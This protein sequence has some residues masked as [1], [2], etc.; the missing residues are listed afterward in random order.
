[1]EWKTLIC[2]TFILL[3]QSVAV[4]TPLIVI[5]AFTSMKRAERGDVKEASLGKT[6]TAACEVT[7]YSL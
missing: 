1:M 2:Y 5:V 4:F 6:L 7:V 3:C